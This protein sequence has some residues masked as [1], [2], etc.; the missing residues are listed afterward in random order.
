[1]S[2]LVPLFAERP[3]SRNGEICV[4][5]S[6]WVVFL[7]QMKRLRWGQSF[8]NYENKGRWIPLFQEPRGLGVFRNI[9]ERRKLNAKRTSCWLKSEVRN[10][11]KV[12]LNSSHV[13]IVPLSLVCRIGCYKE[14]SNHFGMLKMPVINIDSET[15]VKPLSHK[16]CPSK[17]FFG[18]KLVLY[19][20]SKNS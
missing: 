7:A 3:A 5:T 4:I 12:L 17:I 8:L 14:C 1:M 6:T 15:K 11:A 2:P 10:K 19:S 20:C 18:M 13:L 9:H 16:L